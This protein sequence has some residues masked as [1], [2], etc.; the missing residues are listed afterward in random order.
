VLPITEE[1]RDLTLTNP[2]GSQL[3]RLALDQGMFS[4]R[5]DGW[6]KIVD[7][8]TTVDEIT[9]LTPEDEVLVSVSNKMPTQSRATA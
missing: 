4:L 8:L 1:V 9:R 6:H 2:S 3:R 7:G 5:Q